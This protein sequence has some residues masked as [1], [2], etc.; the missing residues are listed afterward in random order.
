MITDDISAL[1]ESRTGLSLSTRFRSDFEAIIHDLAEGDVA[2]LFQRLQ[3]YQDTHPTWQR[4]LQALT[5][6]ETYFFR[7]SVNFRLLGQQLLPA[8]IRQRREHGQLHLNI[9]CAG[10]STGEEPYS[11]AITV[12]ENLP[13]LHRWEINITGTDIN[14]AALEHAQTGIYREWAFRRTDPAFQKRY[15]DETASGWHIKPHI[16]S[17]VT[18]R[19]VNLMDGAPMPQCDVIF[20]RNVLI[21]LTRTHIARM[22]EKIF[23]LLAP[24]GWLILG[25]AEA[26]RTHRER[27]ITHI[28]PGSV[29]YQKPSQSQS[30]PGTRR[31]R[32]PQVAAPATPQGMTITEQYEAAVHALHVDAQP[33]E[34]ERL[35][36][37]LLA[38]QP[39]HAAARTLLASIFANRQAVPEA[40]TQLDAALRSDPMSGDAYYLRATLYLEANQPAD[41]N[42]AL[43]EALYCDRNHPLATFMMGNLLAQ[44]GDR[45]RAAR[46]WEAALR[47]ISDLPPDARVSDLSDMTAASFRTLI[48][49]QLDSLPKAQG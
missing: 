26:V 25:Q 1:I 18:F 6:G 30:A 43:R 27:W 41:A 19:Q 7:D 39:H 23:D 49:T 8:L 11:A 12:L 37:E 46:A 44:A 42:R 9:W 10:C 4:V 40:H 3:Q 2:G 48:Q 35:L 38:D 13:D 21:Y 31:Y 47:I 36:N 29:L 24:G 33:D 45:P 28:F 15:F 16:R 32:E 14:L 22:E 17:M 34:A 20:C 5:I